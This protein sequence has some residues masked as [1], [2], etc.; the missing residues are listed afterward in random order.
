MKGPRGRNR[1]FFP[2][3]L[4][5]AALL[6]WVAGSVAAAQ[7]PAAGDQ[8]QKGFALIAHAELLQSLLAAD[9]GPFHLSAEV[10]LFGLVAGDRAGDYFL[11]AAGPGQWLEQVRFPGYSE[12]SGLYEGVRWRKRNVIDKP[13][14]FHEVAQ[15]LDPASHLELP[16]NAEIKAYR[17]RDLRGARAFCI[18]AS[19]TKDLWQKD[20]AGKAAISPVGFDKGSE[21]T[22]CF[23]A[24]SGVL[25]SAAYQGEM[26]R[27]EYEGQVTLGNKIFPKV[28]RCFEGKE[29]VV[30]ATVRLLARDEAQDASAFA[31]PAG[32]DK[33]PYCAEPEPPQL[34]EKKK[35]SE[36]QLAF[37]KA[38]RQFGTV[39]CLAEI[40]ADGSVHDFT[41]VQSRYGSL[42]GAVKD[43]VSGWRYAP[44]MC[45]GVP[46]PVTIYIAYTFPP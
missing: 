29:L 8:Q 16:A 26:P 34:V 32:A 44:A 6:V 46:V 40:G 20:T 25:L 15:L 14:R 31:V 39:Y 23:D 22:L 12:S 43:A 38:R 18:T 35:L 7:A 13:F 33:W 30:E 2:A 1:E 21:V 11:A 41:W 28:L 3:P 45:H 10:K 36:R 42:A 17:E 4:T 19:P 37:G 24:E 5:I 27:F 9:T